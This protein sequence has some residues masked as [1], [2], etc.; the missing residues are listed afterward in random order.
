VL[1]DGVIHIITTGKTA[2]FEPEPSL[3]DS[4][5]LHPVF[6]S[7]DFTIIFYFYRARSSSAL[8]PTASAEDNIPVF[9]STSDRVALLYPQAPHSLFIT[10]Y[11]LQGY[12]G[13]VLT[14]LHTYKKKYSATCK[15]TWTDSDCV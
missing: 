1:P 5:S 12:G 13:G 2:L 6:T 14:H 3:E 8:H 10:Y 15:Q 9:M 4:A 7:L 11:D